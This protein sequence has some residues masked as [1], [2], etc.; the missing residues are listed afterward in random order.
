REN[1]EP[2]SIVQEIYTDDFTRKRKSRFVTEKDSSCQ[3][4]I[5]K[6]GLHL[7]IGKR[8]CFAWCD[9]LL[10]R[11][12]DFSAEAYIEFADPA[13]H[14]SAGLIFRKASDLNYYYFLVSNQGHFR[15]DQVFNGHPSVLIPWTEHCER[16]GQVFFFRIIARGTRFIFIINNKWAAEIDSETIDAGTFAF[17]AQNY[18]QADSMK[19]S[20][21]Y[22]YVDSRAMEIEKDYS[23]WSEYIEIPDKARFN[24]A[25]SMAAFGQFP[26]AAV[27]LRKILERNAVNEEACL[28]LAQ[29]Y[30]VTGLYQEAADLVRDAAFSPEMQQNAEL[31][32]CNS[33]YLANRFL[34]LRNY[35]T[36]QITE[37]KRSAVVWNHLGN[38]EYFLGNRDAAYKSYSRAAEME[39]TIA[40]FFVNVGNAAEKLGKTQEA[41]DNFNKAAI[42]YFREQNYLEAEKLLPFLRDFSRNAPEVEA[43]EA[44]L[45]FSRGDFGAA[46]KRLE[47]LAEKNYQD[48][49]VYYL[50]GLLYAGR[51]EFSSALEFYDRALGLE[52]D[53]FL[54]QFRKAEACYYLGRDWEDLLRKALDSRQEDP[55]LFNFAGIAFSAK[56][57]SELAEHYFGQALGLEA[58]AEEILINY[59]WL[60]Y[61]QGQ[62]QEALGI[63][64]GRTSAMINNHLGNIWVSEGEYEKAVSCYEKAVQG[65]PGNAAYLENCAGVW[66]ELDGI[67]R[68]EELFVKALDIQES[69]SLYNKIGN[70]AWIRGEYS[71]AQA[72][73]EKALNMA[74]AD[75]DAML[76]LADLRFLKLQYDDAR[77]LIDRAQ[78]IQKTER[79]DGL[80]QKIRNVTVEDLSCA[81]CGRTWTVPRRLPGQ[82]GLSIKGAPPAEAPAGSCPECGK[83]FCIACAEKTLKDQRLHC[84]DCDVPLRLSDPRLRYVLREQFA[85]DP[86][87]KSE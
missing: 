6:K 76:N 46:E 53:F 60:K 51:G 66:L 14:A 42:L 72:S 71:R 37:E 12:N 82:A 20:L 52:S 1:P 3:S 22:F 58:D 78:K 45:D 68:A 33:L 21:R 79:A 39:Q 63:V 38:A 19:V 83:I 17:A 18:D 70:L 47:S 50:L 23:R 65:D 62:L 11:Y 9:N 16:T 44:K 31:A 27:Q 2:D 84:L 56:G 85:P 75:I 55:W 59:S 73:Y 40:G 30:T 4:S 77:K 7:E 34:E 41:F 28:L 64:N 61:E 49:G 5:R 67:S 29:V 48:S 24:F 57:E 25:R 87:N 74:P 43:L 36:G 13:V 32:L 26:I 35:I 54:Y 10:Y 69:A 86:N 8:N 15:L 80:L 81:S